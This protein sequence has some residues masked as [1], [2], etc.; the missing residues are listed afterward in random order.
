MAAAGLIEGYA[1]VSEDGMLADA[2]RVMPP[3]LHF[4]AD[5]RF[6]EA[7]LDRADVVVHGRHSQ[8]R[9]A[10]SH[11]R[12]RLILTRRVPALAPHPSNS[13]ALLWNPAGATFEEAL[14]E[15]GQEGAAVAV[16]GGAEAFALFLSR[17]DVFHLT[18]APDVRLPGGRP[19][20]PDVPARAPEDVLAAH[21]MIADPPV[22]L[23]AAARLTLVTW[24]RRDWIKPDAI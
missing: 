3:S 17:M 16:I 18:R 4:E 14:R 20:F 19:V 23:D 2:H 8:E 12:H 21:G 13:R 24:Q 10:R 15:L 9:Q 11:L 6:F 7:G 5:Q 1:I 22:V